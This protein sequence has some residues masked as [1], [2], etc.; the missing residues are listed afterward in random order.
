M[1][2]STSELLCKQL[3]DHYFPYLQHQDNLRPDWLT[4]PKTGRRLELDRYYGDIKVGIEFDGPHH[5]RDIAGLATKAQSRVQQERDSWKMQR[6]QELGITLI[7]LTIHDLA[8]EQ[9]FKNIVRAMTDLG[10]HA[11][12]TTSRLHNDI[13]FGLANTTG[14]RLVQNPPQHLHRQAE[15]FAR[16]G[17]RGQL[18]KRPSWWRPL[19]GLTR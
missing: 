16:R 11:A 6:C 15:D 12:I 18:K 3:L 13:R 8:N 7:K 4:Y 17:I 9:R 14:R 19:L 1:P 2:V 5:Y 10:L